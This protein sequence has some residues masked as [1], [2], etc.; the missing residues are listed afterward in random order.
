MF[1]LS[2]GGAGASREWI[3]FHNIIV[4]IKILPTFISPGAEHLP[5]RCE[6]VDWLFFG[7]DI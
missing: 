5:S 2:P 4:I 6:L 7:K 1:T 3:Q